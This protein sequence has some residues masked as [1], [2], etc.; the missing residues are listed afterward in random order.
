MR[1]IDP[2]VDQSWETFWEIPPK[3]AFFVDSERARALRGFSLAK[4]VEMLLATPECLRFD[5][6]SREVLRIAVEDDVNVSVRHAVRQRVFS[7]A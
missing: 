6:E 7:P 1:S 5:E 3:F 4:Q 2:Y